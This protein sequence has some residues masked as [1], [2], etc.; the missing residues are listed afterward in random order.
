M[1]SIPGAFSHAGFMPHGQCFL[2]EPRLLGLM[3]VS[4]GLTAL[5]YFSIPLA[6]LYYAVRR[7]GSG[8]HWVLL[9]FA[10]FIGACGLTHLMGVYTLWVPAYWGEGLIQAA[11]ALIS[12]ATAAALWPMMP[13]LLAVPTPGELQRANALLR[14][15][16]AE[17]QRA[18]SSLREQQRL[19]QSMYDHLPLATYVKDEQGRFRSVN[20]AMAEYFGM[21]PEAML[22]RT[23]A[24]LPGMD[25]PL[26]ADVEAADRTVV[27]EGTPHET[28]EVEVVRPDGTPQVRRIRKLPLWDDAG[29]VTGLLGLSEDI[30]EAKRHEA[31]LRRSEERYRTLLASLP[32]GV[33]IH[34][35]LVPVYVN[36]A[37][38]RTVG[39]ESPEAFLADTRQRPA[40]FFVDPEERAGALERHRARMRGEAVTEPIHWRVV[41]AD[42]RSVWLESSHQRVDWKGEPAMQSTHVDI[43]ER[44]EAAE[45]LQR[46][47]EELER[48]Y[49]E[50][51]AE[52]RLLANLVEQSA[53]GVVVTDV[54]GR[55]VRA[56][57][58]FRRLTGHGE[59]ALRDMRLPALAPE[60]ARADLEARLAEAGEA[61]RSARFEG[62]LRRRD[63]GEVPVE[64]M[65]DTYRDPEDGAGYLYAFVADISERKRNEARI[66]ELNEDL[67][68]RVVERTELLAAANRELESFAYSVSHDLRQPLRA[69]TGFSQAVLEDYRDRLD[70]AGRDF[71]ERI[72]AGAARMKQLIDDLLVLSRITRGELHRARVD[73]SAVAG[74]VLEGLREA[75]PDRRVEARIAP[76]LEA[77][78]DP[79]LVRV[80][81]EN[82]V[83]N[84]WKFTGRSERPRI[85]IGRE[86]GPGGAFFVRDNGAGFDMAYADKLFAPFQRLHTVREF[87]GSGVGLATV[88]RI[89]L[90]HGG[91]VWAEGQEGRGATFY[92]TL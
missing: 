41:R 26:L 63:D 61:G 60:A 33:M 73:L 70:E 71:L 21:A 54:D 42:G 8:F 86:N 81:L 62:A 19:L 6:I 44:I 11:T 34:R 77:E 37:F 64:W 10:A 3:A 72:S 40:G 92:F 75:Q 25:G 88:Q 53:Q 12:L 14:H 67:E 23:S 17:R 90:R 69:I 22:G 50:R 4:D 18:E 91:R 87:P 2:W 45:A 27:A 65:L 84:A 66:R 1:H 74:K 15:E 82:L 35:D 48:R 20:R 7:P 89:V 83:G 68:R 32:V 76:Q 58:A 39:Y 16:V 56:N 38:A 55:I 59:A 5:A 29:R 57:P 79:R 49:R 9:L 31:A 13:R 36:A 85:E 30:T 28:P 47:H 52:V 51:T 80:L 46:A 78:A 43:S 24:E